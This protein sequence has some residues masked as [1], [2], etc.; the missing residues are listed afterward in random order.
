MELAK[1]RSQLKNKNFWR[2]IY[3]LPFLILIG[4][5][6]FKNR[7][8]DIHEIFTLLI[9]AMQLVFIIVL[10]CYLIVF[11]VKRTMFTLT[12]VLI[13]GALFL[14]R[15]SDSLFSLNL[16][17][18]PSENTISLMSWNLQR[19]GALHRPQDVAKN[20]KQ[21][22]ETINVNSIQV[23]VLQEIS[24][25][26]TKLIA[27]NMDLNTDDFV[28]TDYYG[29]NRGRKG[30]IAIIV[31]D[32]NLRLD[33]KAAPSL[34]PNWQ[35]AYI[36]LV[37]KDNRHLNILGIHIAPPKVS[38]REIKSI[39]KNMVRNPQI[40]L[41]DLR[42]NAR[43]YS[44][45]IR[46]QNK[47]ADRITQIFSG[48]KDPTVIAGDFNATPEA[49]LHSKLSNHLNDAWIT[50]GNGWGST[51]NWLGFIPLRIDFVYLTKELEAIETYTLPS[52]FSDHNPII[53]TIIF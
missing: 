51:R 18:V 1:T 44:S 10:L 27:Q 7:L 19:L 35:C 9:T 3:M 53:S 46:K 25:Y 21:V 32:K 15:Y 16:K 42:N 26:Q 39:A 17:T 49:P 30:G 34:P 4:L 24:L 6:L 31:V 33:S 43:I 20:I 50:R 12:V 5:L 40:A 14:V 37:S 28:W 41:R 11:I 22:I 48:F 2:G 29:T 52:K 38:E 23:V 8:I 45:Q 36:D 47:Q 13:T